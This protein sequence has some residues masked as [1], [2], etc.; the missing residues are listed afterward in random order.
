MLRVSNWVQSLPSPRRLAAFGRETTSSP[1]S[2]VRYQQLPDADEVESRN[3]SSVSTS[4][5]RYDVVYHLQKRTLLVAI[6]VIAC[7]A[8]FFFGYDQGVMGGVNIAEDY[9]HKTMHY[10]YKDA[11][12]GAMVVTNAWL[13]GG[14]VS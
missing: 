6:N 4:I 1:R 5:N 13:Q 7:L 11:K 10:G 9:Y 3:G 14:I 2:L 12:S 8:I